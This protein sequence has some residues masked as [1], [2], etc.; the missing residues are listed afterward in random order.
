MC[1]QGSSADSSNCICR[2]QFVPEIMPAAG[3]EMPACVRNPSLLAEGGQSCDAPCTGTE[4]SSVQFV[5]FPRRIHVY[6][7]LHPA[8]DDVRIGVL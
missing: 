2:P 7:P 3:V 5:P 8:N 4:V 6:S 1:Q